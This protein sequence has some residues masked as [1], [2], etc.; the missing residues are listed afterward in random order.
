MVSPAAIPPSAW[1]AP[2]PLPWGHAVVAGPLPAFPR[3]LLFKIGCPSSR[4][5]PARSP[6]NLF[7]LLLQK[8]ILFFGP[9]F[10]SHWW[11]K[12]PDPWWVGVSPTPPPPRPHSSSP[13]TPRR[14]WH[15]AFPPSRRGRSQEACPRR[16]PLPPPLLLTPWSRL[17]TRFGPSHRCRSK[18]YP[19]FHTDTKLLFKADPPPRAGWVGPPPGGRVQPRGGGVVPP[20]GGVSPGLFGS[21]Q[22]PGKKYYGV[23]FL[24]ENLF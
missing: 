1:L 20:R 17:H 4:C 12:Y 8:A 16:M 22:R 2:W 21:C 18:L 9:L 5:T 10:G 19:G 14:L 13:F 23:F 11:Q 3:R 6:P 15:P 7:L 24:G